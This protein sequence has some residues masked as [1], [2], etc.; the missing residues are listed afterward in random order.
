MR[1][2]FVLHQGTMYQPFSNSRSS[3]WIAVALSAGV[4][5]ASSAL[6]IASMAGEQMPD[7]L[8][9]PGVFAAA[10]PQ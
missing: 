3:A 7:Q 6:I 2:L 5:A 8:L 1:S 9:L 4:A 10:Q